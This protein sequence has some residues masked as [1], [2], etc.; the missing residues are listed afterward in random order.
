[1][2]FEDA[3]IAG[4]ILGGVIGLIVWATDV[5]A[6]DFG[7]GPLIFIGVC[8]WGGVYCFTT[9]FHDRSKDE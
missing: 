7:V 3:K 6:A 8:A 4:A 2:K 9:L 1:M 5:Y